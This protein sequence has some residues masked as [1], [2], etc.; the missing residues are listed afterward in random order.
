MQ[1]PA[2]LNAR[3]GRIAAVA[4]GARPEG[5]RL[6]A[7]FNPPLLRSASIRKFMVGFEMFGESQR[8]VTPEQAA[9]MLRAAGD[10]R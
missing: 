6:H 10:A 5:W 1:L 8:D 3:L 4:Q 7:H 9:A 2:S